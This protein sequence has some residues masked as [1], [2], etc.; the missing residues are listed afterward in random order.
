[1]QLDPP[2]PPKVIEAEDDQDEID[3]LGHMTDKPLKNGR[4]YVDSKFVHDLMDNK[5]ISTISFQHYYQDMYG[6]R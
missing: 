4:K 3:G 6:R 1:M 2:P 5:T